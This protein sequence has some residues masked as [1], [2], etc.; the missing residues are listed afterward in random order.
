MESDKRG[1]SDEGGKPDGPRGGGW[2]DLALYLISLPRDDRE[3]FSRHAALD[4]PPDP[5][6]EEAVTRLLEAYARGNP[7]DTP[8]GLLAT[9]GAQAG[10]AGDAEFAVRAGRAAL[11]LAKTGGDRALAHVSLAQT[12]FQSRRREEEL[13]LFEHHCRAAVEEG[14]SGTFCYER[15]ATLYEYRGWTN[16]AERICRSA[17]EVLGREDPRSVQKFQKRLDRLSGG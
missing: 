5:E 13:A 11:E 14:H 15:L 2:G 9:T 10:F 7:S 6:D 3:R 12:H 17:V 1:E 4:L 8:S 16:E